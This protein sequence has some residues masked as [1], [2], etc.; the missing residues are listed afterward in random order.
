MKMKETMK[1]NLFKPDPTKT[2][3]EGHKYSGS[4]KD[5]AT[6]QRL[7]QERKLC[8]CSLFKP[9]AYQMAP[10]A[11]VLNIIKAELIPTVH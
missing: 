11:T 4:E 1:V 7:S 8:L 5:S 2:C 9:I 6:Q 3:T 10:T